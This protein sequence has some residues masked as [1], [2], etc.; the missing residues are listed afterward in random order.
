[1]L[2][3]DVLVYSLLRM[4]LKMITLHYFLVVGKEQS[5]AGLRNLFVLTVLASVPTF[6]QDGRGRWR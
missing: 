6:C 3:W 5:A 1:M 4:K 2:N